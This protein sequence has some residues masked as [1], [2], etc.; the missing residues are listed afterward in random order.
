MN[1]RYFY[2][3]LLLLIFT[4]PTLVN[5]FSIDSLLKVMSDKDNYIILSSD[6][7]N[8]REFIHVSLSKLMLSGEDKGKEIML[9]PQSVSTWPVLIEPGEVVLDAGDEVRV[10]IIRN[11]DRQENDI[12]V[13][14]SFIPDPER[15][16][17]NISALQVALGYKTWLVI[18]GT[19][20]FTGDVSAKREGKE[21][22]IDNAS[23]K[24]I[25]VLPENCIG[26][27]PSDCIDSIISLPGTKKQI[28]S[29]LIRTTLSFYEFSTLSKKIKEITL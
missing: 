27:K 14:V 25:R 23:N 6:K 1:M 15:V 21:I 29:S 19:S 22:I 3:L 5:A 20:P 13:G 16:N 28:D 2:G 7:Q 11:S 18:P 8:G 17:I 4:T 12:L 24:I 10:N 9:D 26:V